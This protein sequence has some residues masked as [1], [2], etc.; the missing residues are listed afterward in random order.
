MDRRIIRES[1]KKPRASAPEIRSELGLENIISVSTVQRRLTEVGLNARKPAKVPKLTRR[2]LKA[3][4][5][6][7]RRYGHWT[8][9][10]W[11]KV[12][13]SDESKINKFSND[14]RSYMRR[15]VGKRLN[16][17]Y[18]IGTVKF[19]GGSIL[20]WGAFSWFGIGPLHLIE[21]NM[22]R[23]QYRDIL[24]NVMLPYAR[25]QMPGGWIFQQDNDPKHTSKLTKDWFQGNRVKVLEWPAQSPD[26]NPI[27][28]LWSEVK[29]GLAGQNFRNS[30][31][32]FQTTQ[33]I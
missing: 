5:D 30:A 1:I 22:D 3:R 12:I 4:L 27:E 16:P 6:F 20:V 24:Q 15:P 21:G 29:R 17:R 8:V 28:N 33:Q 31:D 19:G 14:G 7:A 9:E 13:F 10:D 25:G 18:T 32:L 11:K 23:F 2:H 26:L